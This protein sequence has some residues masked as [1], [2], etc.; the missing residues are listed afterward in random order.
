M[1]C[2]ASESGS[3][4]CVRRWLL[5]RM[6]PCSQEFLEPGS[7]RCSVRIF[8]SSSPA[9]PGVGHPCSPA[10][11]P[12]LLQIPRQTGCILASH[13]SPVVYRAR[14]G[15][16]LCPDVPI[17]PPVSVQRCHS[18]RTGLE[19][20]R[21]RDRFHVDP[22]PSHPSQIWAHMQHLMANFKAVCDFLGSH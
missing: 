21:P 5:A 3:T 6:W 14:V 20:G 4:L 19:A 1:H 10:M 13:I 8:I 11:F 9:S 15:S 7:A 16:R 22:G 12:N 17:A 18:L 2:K